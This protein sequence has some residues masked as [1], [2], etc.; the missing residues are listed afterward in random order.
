MAQQHRDHLKRGDRAA[1]RDGA[2]V[3]PHLA[4]E[5]AESEQ[6]LKEVRPPVQHSSMCCKQTFEKASWQHFY[7][8]HPL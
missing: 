6:R 3:P 4:K 7:G 8:N 2:G 5:A 1:R